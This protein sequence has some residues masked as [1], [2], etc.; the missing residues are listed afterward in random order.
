MTAPDPTPL[1]Q[2]AW[3]AIQDQEKVLRHLALF[4]L[5]HPELGYDE[6]QASQCL[7]DTLSRHGFQAS[8]G[9]GNLPTAFRAAR[10]FGKGATVAFLAEYDALPH[11]GHGCGHNLIGPAAVGAAIGVSVL[12]PQIRGTV[13]VIGTP[14]EEF[15]GQ[16][17]GKLRLLEAGAFEDID[18]ALMMHPQFEFRLPGQDLGF[19]A[20]EFHFRG[21][22]AHAAADP[23]NGAN[24]L[25]GLLLT[26]N[27]INALRQQ[28]R[29]DVR[30]HGIVTHGG[31]APNMIPESASAQLM[32]RAPEPEALEALYSRVVDCAQ[33]GALASGTELEVIRVT[34]VQSTWINTTLCRLIADN[35]SQLGIPLKQ[36]PLDTSGSTDF[37]NLS[38]AVPS[39]MFWAGTHPP[40]LPWHSAKIA[41]ASGEEMAL[42]GM[43]DS[44]RI[45]AGVAID[46]LVRPELLTQVQ[47]E[48]E[49][50]PSRPSL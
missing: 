50:G 35:A 20:C 2:K 7:A 34:T 49:L 22:S 9:L 19:I 43:M 47:K 39:A 29:P 28:F 14:A 21:R 45:L 42:Q 15:L 18:V 26:F 38:R 12:F 25:D 46:L 37:G 13:C 11:V 23:W 48:F 33:A 17:E 36:E 31:Q 27:N 10:G 16:V 41:T 44:A 32:V 30:V 8:L 5:G 6:H 1:K 4:I 40:G 3:Q 24:A